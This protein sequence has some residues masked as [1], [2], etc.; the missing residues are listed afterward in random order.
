LD[1]EPAV[2]RYAQIPRASPPDTRWTRASPHKA[3][4]NSAF[5]APRL[6]VGAQ[7]DK[8][9]VPYKRAAKAQQYDWNALQTLVDIMND[10]TATAA[11]RVRCAELILER[12]HGKPAYLQDPNRDPDF[13]PL[14]ERL[15][16]YMRR[17]EIE[18]N[19]GKVVQLSPAT[20]QATAGRA[21]SVPSSLPS[22]AMPR[23]TTAEDDPA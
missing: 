13:V 3:S 20:D 16:W 19:A 5:R 8:P 11:A 6:A 1:E 15:K 10:D 4:Q 9:R 22:A 17:D 23:A 14:A 2:E 7:F 18:G 12:A 21:L